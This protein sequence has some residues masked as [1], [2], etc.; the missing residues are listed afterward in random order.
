[1]NGGHV[2]V[3]SK[4]KLQAIAERNGWSFERARGYVDGET[5]RLRAKRPS[6]YV[7]VGIDEYSLGFRAGYYERRNGSPA[8]NFPGAHEEQTSAKE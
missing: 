4:E 5:F 2:N 6:Q 7:V 1:M 8:V 3:A